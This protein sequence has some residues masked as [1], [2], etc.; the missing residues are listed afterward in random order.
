M[1]SASIC[2]GTSTTL[3]ATPSLAGGTYAWSP[4]GQTTASVS[5]TPASTT[6]YSVTYTLTGCSTTSSGIVTILANLAIVTNSSIAASQCNNA[7]LNIPYTVNCNYNAGNIFTA[8]LSDATGSFLSPTSIG[9]LSAIGNGT[10]NATIPALALAGTNY[11]IR[12]VSSSPVTIGNNNGTN[13]SISACTFTFNVKLI[14]Q[15]FYSGSGSMRATIDPVL[16]PTVCDSVKIELHN[17]TTPFALVDI[18]TSTI[19]LTGTGAFTFAGTSLGQSYY[20]VVKHRNAL[21]TWSAS[22]VSMTSGGIYDFSNAL[23]K[24]F[25]SNQINVSAGVFAIWSGDVTNGTTP[26]LQDGIINDSDFNLIQSTLTTFLSG[27]NYRDLSG[28]K[29]VESSDYS[30]I[31]NNVKAGIVVSKP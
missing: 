8:Q 10:I 22:T 6:T 7:A 24:A 26:G 4:G 25:G 13:I 15:G 18:A 21:E 27:Y 11:R 19:N 9:S 23:N 14:I 16:Y 5:V 1:N 12:I 29:F 30:L 17:A 3:T 2:A 20:I 31:D 28:D